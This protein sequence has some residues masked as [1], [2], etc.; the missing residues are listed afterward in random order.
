MSTRPPGL[1]PH[2]SRALRNRH[3]GRPPLAP[4]QGA[5][6]VLQHPPHPNTQSVATARKTCAP[7]PAP[8]APRAPPPAQVGQVIKTE[9][10]EATIDNRCA[11]RDACQV[12]TQV[13]GGGPDGQ[14]WSQHCPGGRQAQSQQGSGDEAKRPT[15]SPSRHG[16]HCRCEGSCPKSATNSAGNTRRWGAWRWGPPH[17]LHG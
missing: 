3:F 17:G 13:A 4:S 10:G 5:Q 6:V 14:C 8:H 7:R 11:W 12:S 1:A 16:V 15:V 9:F 2:P